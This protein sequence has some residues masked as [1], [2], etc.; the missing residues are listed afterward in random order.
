MNWFIPK[1][2][3]TSLILVAISLM[4]N[5]ETQSRLAVLHSAWFY[6]RLVVTVFCLF[7]KPLCRSPIWPSHR[8]KWIRVKTLLWNIQ[9]EKRI[10]WIS[11]SF[12]CHYVY[13]LPFCHSIFMC[14]HAYVRLNQIKTYYLSYLYSKLVLPG[15]A[16]P[17]S[18]K[19]YF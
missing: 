15:P 2:G 8:S 6:F 1:I 12:L 17:I 5:M 10:T 3:A 11:L 13:F 16:G 7:Y 14:V 18:P 19:G 9:Y 4:T